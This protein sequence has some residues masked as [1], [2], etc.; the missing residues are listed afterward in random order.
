LRLLAWYEEHRQPFP[1]RTARDPYLALVAAVCAQQTQMSRV[2]MLY[3][4]W[5]ASFPTLEDA[6]RASNAEALRAWGRGGYPRRALSLRDAAR[7][8]VEHHGG[9]LPRNP[10][11]L[12]ALPG[13]GPFTAAIVL[14]FGFGDDAAAVDTN[15]V[16]VIGRVVLGDLQPATDSPRAVIDAWAE[17]L[18]PRG[19]AA[20]WNPALMDYG[21][22]VC[23]P[24]P[25]CGECVVA[26]LCAAYPRFEAGERAEPV[27]AQPR[28]EGSDRWWRG[29]LLHALREHDGEGM[30]V[31]ALLEAIAPPDGE[32]D[33]L[34]ALLGA[35]DA[36]GLAWMSDGRCG[37]GEAPR[38]ERADGSGT[39]EIDV[40]R[41]RRTESR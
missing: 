4:A 14:S 10:E 25:R 23:T 20:D 1:W 5:T 19:R 13:V 22:R 41:A 17:R 40:K 32:R 28:F 29:R 36:E 7:V 16:R 21:A 34:R 24:R 37:L 8:C 11:A 27:R 39:L 30:E 35:L 12:L 18:L 26:T 9:A 31:E 3:D 33:R 15:I 2:L 38:T 6:A